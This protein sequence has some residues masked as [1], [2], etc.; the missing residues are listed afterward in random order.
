MKFIVFGLGS[1]GASLANQL[2]QLGHEVIG[3]DKKLELADKF[4]HSVTHAI[5]LDSTSKDA[6]EQIP[7]KDV[8]A[9]KCIGGIFI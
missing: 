8:D 7:L 6:M 3:V 1:F 4:K 9:A 5:A 2:V